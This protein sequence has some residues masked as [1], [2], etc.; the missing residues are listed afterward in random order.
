VPAARQKPETGSRVQRFG[1]RLA[2]HKVQPRQAWAVLGPSLSGVGQ[3]LT[4]LGINSATSLVAG[5]MLGSVTGTFEKYPGVLVMVPAAIGLRGNVFSSLGSRVSTAIHTG[6]YQSSLRPGSV[7]GDNAATSIVQTLLLAW[8]LAAIAA[9]VAVAFGLTDVSLLDLVT[10]SVLG[11][12]GA[13]VVVLTAT[14]VLVW[15]AVRYEWDLDNLVAPVVSTLG[16][17]VTVPALWLATFALGHGTLGTIG[18]IAVAVSSAAVAIWGVLK[19]R[20]RVKRIL[21]ESLPILAVAGALSTLAGVMLEHQLS[22]FV[23]LPALLVLQPAFVSSAGALGGL[24]AASLSTSLHLGTV[25][26]TRVPSLSVR[27]DMYRIAVLSLAVYAFNGVGAHFVAS[28]LG[29]N[30][31]GVGS[32]VAASMLG[33]CIAVAFVLLVA[34][35]G[36]LAAH[37][38][39][40]DPDTYGI[41]IVT[42]SVDFAGTLVLIAAVGALAIA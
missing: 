32:M 37:Q 40:V 15:V 25:A 36:A 11:G 27:H 6:E 9:A 5:A 35:Y 17:V 2:L 19:G 41:P 21:A 22:T 33:G 34:Y 4:A 28:V 38:L 13:S 7:V 42:S 29:Q 14:V 12:V 3:S 24:M 1:T 16:D 10:I 18:Q 39:R 23:A 8:I 26:P 20:P 31:P 30:S